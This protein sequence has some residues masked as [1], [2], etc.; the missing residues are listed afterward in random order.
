[1]ES[2]GVQ[3]GE[4]KMDENRRGEKKCTCVKLLACVSL[5]KQT[6]VCIK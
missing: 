4:D 5:R 3:E 6:R 2:D 1:M